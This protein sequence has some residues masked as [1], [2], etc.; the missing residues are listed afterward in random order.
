LWYQSQ[1]TTIKND[2]GS[3]EKAETRVK[4][5]KAGEG[6]LLLRFDEYTKIRNIENA[7]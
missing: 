2:L 1:N 7:I 4:Q 5:V 6:R 3:G